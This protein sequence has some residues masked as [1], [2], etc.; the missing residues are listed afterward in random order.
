MASLKWAYLQQLS[1]AYKGC[2]DRRR[3]SAN[4]LLADSV[5][6]ADDAEFIRKP[7]FERLNIGGQPLNAQELRNSLYS[8]PFNDLIIELART[9]LFQ[10]L[11]GIRVE[12]VC[13]FP[14]GKQIV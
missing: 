3:I 10:E 9:P 1:A 6:S 13:D 4:V 2:L 11:W 7:V 5:K 8:G 12:S 14:C